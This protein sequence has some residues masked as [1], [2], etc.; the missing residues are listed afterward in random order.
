MYGIQS[1]FTG[2]VLYPPSGSAWRLGQDRNLEAL[3]GWGARF[4]LRQ[5]DDAERRAAL[6]GVPLAEVPDVQAI[7]LDEP[8]DTARTKAHEVLE[9]GV[10]PRVF[11][12]KQGYGRPRLKKYLSE[13]QEGYV[14]TTFWAS[15]DFSTPHELGPISWSHKESGHSQQGVDELTAIVGPGHEFKTVKPLKLFRRLIQIWCPADGLI[16]DP[17]AG[18]GTAGHAA[19]E[20]DAEGGQ[21]QFILIEQGRPDRGDSYARSLSA[22]RLQ[23]VVTGEWASGPRP[24]LGGGFRFAALDKKVDADALMSMEREDLADTIIASHFDGPAGRRNTLINVPPADGYKYLVARNAEGEGL[25]LIWNGTKGNRRSTRPAR[26]RR[27]GRNLRRGTTYTRA[28]TGSRRAMSCSTKS[29][30]AS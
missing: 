30:T 19:L 13:L 3:R 11:F 29:L 22:N 5:L 28:S 1:P 20:L 12:L 15:D 24:A 2:E 23:R 8:L 4:V 14:P 17:F 6:I 10:W 26:R 21:R 25:F 16:L 18:T 7:M 9:H 27:G